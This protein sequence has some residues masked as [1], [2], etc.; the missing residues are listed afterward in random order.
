MLLLLSA[1]FSVALMYAFTALPAW[2]DGLIHK[3][4]GA[5]TGDPAYHP[6]RY[7]LFIDS[8]GIKWI[9]IASL[10]I[11]VSLIGIGFRFRKTG[12]AWLGAILLF[13]PVFS[14]FAVSMFYLSGLGLFNTLLYPLFDVSFQILHLGDVVLIPYWIVKWFFGL[15]NWYAHDFIMY[16]FMLIGA[17]IFVLSVFTWLKA[18]YNKQK[19][20]KSW[21]YRISRHPQYLGWIIWSYGLMLYG[22]T[23]NNMKKTWGW[24]G[25]LA[26]LLS[27]M[28]I[29]GI[30][31]LEEI[32]MAE[33]AG[34]EYDQYRNKTPF[35]FP[36]PAL[37]H[38][39]LAAP[40]KW[41][42]RDRRIM[43]PRQVGFV[44][45]LYTLIFMA[46]SLFWVDFGQNQTNQPAQTLQANQHTIDSLIQEAKRPQHR[47]TLSS[48]IEKLSSLGDISHPYLIELIKDEN[49]DIREFAID[50]TARENISQAVPLLVEALGDSVYRVRRSAM[51]ALS[52]LKPAETKDTLLILLRHNTERYDPYDLITVLSS[53]GAKE[54]IPYLIEKTA[55]P[56]WYRRSRALSQLYQVDPKQAWPHVYTA[57]DD[58]T[59]MVRRD[60]VFMILEYLPN[61]AI[62][63][64]ERVLDDPEWEVR[65]YAKCAIKE[66][67]NNM[68]KK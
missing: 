14:T 10:C 21:L 8:Y 34:A 62:P 42:K 51:Q 33:K 12:V 20:A 24:Q 53:L 17:L 36:L 1:I 18:Y 4:I 25:S 22:P 37:V 15:F 57:L 23:L 19:V 40:A 28:V 31:L 44:V 26:W 63:H 6:E 68:F 13:L 64:L 49:N 9:G 5:P 50:F 41:I 30:C 67:E 39:V 47:R 3:N 38:Q 55:D 27:T 16:A 54:V 7:Q 35:L 45:G 46:L 59:S 60:A 32:R 61:D 65:F 2:L 56:Q 52:K 66:I 29:I 43:K 48:H 11:V 58:T